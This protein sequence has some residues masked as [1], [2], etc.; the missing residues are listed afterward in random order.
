MPNDTR[1][2]FEKI[3]ALAAERLAEVEDFVDFIASRAQDRAFTKAA[4]AASASSFARIWE[5][6][7]DDTYDTL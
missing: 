3:Q 6:P 7:D 5:N 4:P 1:A 2:L